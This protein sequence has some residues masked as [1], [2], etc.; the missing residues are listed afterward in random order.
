MGLQELPILALA[1]SLHD[2]QII[3]VDSNRQYTCFA[4]GNGNTLLAILHEDEH[5]DTLTSLQGFF[6]TSYFCG[7]CLKP[8]NQ[9]GEQDEHWCGNS[10]CPS[11]HK[12]TDLNQHQCFVQVPA[13]PEELKGRARIVQVNKRT[14]LRHEARNNPNTATEGEENEED[15]TYHPP[16]LVF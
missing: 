1:P 7:Q 12:T 13:Y 9:Q 10:E 4:F 14:R 11:C 6:G 8:Y 15:N 3:V 2:Y 5:Y 16:L